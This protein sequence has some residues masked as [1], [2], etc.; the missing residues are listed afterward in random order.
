MAREPVTTVEKA[1]MLV[2]GALMVIAFPLIGFI[3]TVAGSMSPMITYSQGDS[4]GHALSRAGVP[5]GA[6]IVSS[7]L[8]GPN[9]RAYLIA[10]GLVLFGLLAIYLVFRPGEKPAE[11]AVGERAE[12]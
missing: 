7:P 5:D 2:V 4:T 3:V 1:V 11:T 9:L 8:V 6:Q 12:H 10:I